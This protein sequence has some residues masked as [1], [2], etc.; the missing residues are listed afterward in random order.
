[1]EK[2]PVAH[3]Y[4]FDFWPTSARQV[5]GDPTGSRKMSK[6]LKKSPKTPPVSTVE[7]P[8]Q[9]AVGVELARLD[10]LL[11]QLK[12]AELTAKQSGF[13]VGDQL[14]TLTAAPYKMTIAEI[15]KRYIR[16][17][18][19]MRGRSRANL[20]ELRTISETVKP[21][22]R[23]PD[24]AVFVYQKL[25]KAAKTIEKNIKTELGVDYQIDIQRE[26]QEIARSSNTR[27]SSRNIAKAMVTKAREYLLPNR[28]QNALAAISE[29]PKETVNNCH[30]QDYVE[31]IEQLP[32]NSIQ[33]L[34][35]DPPYG[36]YFK[37]KDG[38]L[39]M[40]TSSAALSSGNNMDRDN[41]I[42]TTIAAFKSAAKKLRKN[43]VIILWQAG[44]YL[45]PEII[46]AAESEGFVISLPIVWN[47]IKPQ[48]GDPVVAIQLSTEFAWIIH[49]KD[50]KVYNINLQPRGQ[51]REWPVV[52][53]SATSIQ[54]KHSWNKPMESNI[55]ILEWFTSENDLVFDA[56]GCSG[57][58]C[59]AAIQ[60]NRKWVYCESYKENFCLGFRNIEEAKKAMNVGIPTAAE[61]PLSDNEPSPTL[62][63]EN[64]N[65]E[66]VAV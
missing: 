25:V 16:N 17:G 55:D 24:V 32:N 41:A 36:A 2:V 28:Y 63:N 46:A 66:L 26:I 29:S 30:N 61:I 42:K 19:P 47:K 12:G 40:S 10:E 5:S 53:Q 7:L 60:K 35:L 43:G 9:N 62:A 3:G 11:E 58:M 45:R 51:V 27:A 22:D 39:D 54:E 4:R 52:H 6:S 38:H 37:N 15:A 57:G 33:L 44:M 64:A 13:T 49:R 65:A 8:A 34:F 48:A 23:N 18:K 56:F 31:V 59:V 20:S 1:L 21:A 14:I 50:E